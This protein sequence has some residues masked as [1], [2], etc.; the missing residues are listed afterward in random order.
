MAKR[1][2]SKHKEDIKSLLSGHLHLDA[3]EFKSGTFERY[4]LLDEY[5]NGTDLIT[6]GDIKFEVK[7]SVD[8]NLSFALFTIRSWGTP[9]AEADPSRNA[10]MITGNIRTRYSLS[11]DAGLSPERRVELLQD[12]IPKICLN[13]AWPFWRQFVYDCGQKMGLPAMIVPLLVNAPVPVP[14]TEAGEGKTSP[15]KERRSD[16]HSTGGRRKP[17]AEK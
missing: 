3:V 14:A 4:D 6:N 16:P 1:E 15:Q 2:S 17:L 10:Y 13:H 7:T 8:G 12:L 11:G 5:E 9:K